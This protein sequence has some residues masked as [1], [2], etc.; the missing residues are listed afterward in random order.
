MDIYKDR[1]TNL[2]VATE[3]QLRSAELVVER[4]RY[5]Q[6]TTAS[7]IEIWAENVAN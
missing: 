6:I 3:D 2:T 7:D 5:D 1:A 4:W